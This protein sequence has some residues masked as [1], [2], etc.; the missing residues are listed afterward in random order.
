[1]HIC[2]TDRAV[3]LEPHSFTFVIIL[4][5]HR[6]AAA[7]RVT[8][9]L[10]VTTAHSAN[11]TLIAVVDHL[12]RIIIIEATDF[13]VILCEIILTACACFRFRLFELACKTLN[14]RYFVAFE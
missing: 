10:A 14:G 9:E 4:H 1:M 8:V 7:A 11:T 12:R 13:T 3:L 6:V 2:Q 5:K